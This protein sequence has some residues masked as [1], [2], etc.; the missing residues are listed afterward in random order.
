MEGFLLYLYIMK[1]RDVIKSILINEDENGPSS[2]AKRAAKEFLIKFMFSDDDEQDSYIMD[3][4]IDIGRTSF[5]SLFI[6]GS[7]YD[8]TYNFDV[9][10][11]KYPSFTPATWNDPPEYGH[12]ARLLEL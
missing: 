5:V 6:D 3:Y 11:Q 12:H 7:S 1:F 10:V 9:D 4:D 2:E 8:F